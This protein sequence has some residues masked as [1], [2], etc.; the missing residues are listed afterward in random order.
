MN[1]KFKYRVPLEI[2]KHE[3]FGFY[4]RA[5]R[6]A[7]YLKS[8]GTLGNSNPRYAESKGELVQFIRSRSNG[9]ILDKTNI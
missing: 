3:E 7:R 6:S 9:I 2:H 5:V 4:A 1:L 8:N